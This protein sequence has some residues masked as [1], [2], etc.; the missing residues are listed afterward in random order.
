MQGSY[1][2]AEMQIEATH[3]LPLA[4]KIT[5]L[6]YFFVTLGRN[7]QSGDQVVCLLRDNASIASPKN[8]FVVLCNTPAGQESQLVF[9]VSFNILVSNIMNGVLSGDRILGHDLNPVFAT[10]LER[11]A[12]KKGVSITFTTSHA[13]P[14]RESWLLVHPRAPERIIR[15]ILPETID[16]F[17]DF[18]EHLN[19]DNAVSRISAQLPSHCR[20]ITRETLFS[21]DSWIAS[22]TLIA[23]IRELLRK[24]VSQAEIDLVNLDREMLSV[25]ETIGLDRLSDCNATSGPQSVISW[26]A[27]STVPVP[28]EPIDSRAMFSDNRT[29]WLV[30]LT[31]ELGLLLCEWMVRRGSRYIVITS[32]SPRVQESWLTKM[33]SVGATIRIYTKSVFPLLLD[34]IGLSD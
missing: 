4:I 17:L 3:S 20:H 12:T 6:T 13:V 22:I 31:G 30:G 29:Y 26:I 8:G 1:E 11:E 21:K 27:S 19:S 34:G 28:V 32:R 14:N 33:E 16:I 15:R 10:I 18:S 23:A 24:A 7:L 25:V 2:D 5:D 9:L